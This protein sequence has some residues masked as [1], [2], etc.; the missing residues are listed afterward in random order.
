MFHVKQKFVSQDD[1]KRA[2]QIQKAICKAL[3]VYSKY[4]ILLLI[5]L[6]LG[7]SVEANDVILVIDVYDAVAGCSAS[8]Q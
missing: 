8:L 7:D 1:K 6:V 5:V 3:F 2:L 4:P